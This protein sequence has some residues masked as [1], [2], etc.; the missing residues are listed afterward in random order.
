MTTWNLRNT[1]LFKSTKSNTQLDLNLMLS[2]SAA[3]GVVLL[4]FLIGKLMRQP[5]RKTNDHEQSNS[6]LVLV[7]VRLASVC[8]GTQERSERI[9]VDEKLVIR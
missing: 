8:N 2:S 3:L 5:K 1:A 4:A 9:K 6:S 7:A